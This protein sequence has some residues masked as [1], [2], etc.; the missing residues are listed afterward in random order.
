MT[1]LS[2]F[3]QNLSKPQ[4]DAIEREKRYKEHQKRVFAKSVATDNEP[5]PDMR[6]QMQQVRQSKITHAQDVLS[7]TSSAKV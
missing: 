7:A 5:I 3:Q 6:K 1:L 4:L 2:Q